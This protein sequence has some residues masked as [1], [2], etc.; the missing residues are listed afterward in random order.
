MKRCA[1]ILRS[2]LPAYPT[3]FLLLFGIVFLFVSAYLRWC[4]LGTN[5]TLIKS[6]VDPLE[7]LALAAYVIEFAACAGFF[8]CFRPGNY[9]VR[10]LL[11]WVCLP[12]LAG[13]L[14][15]IYSCYV[16]HAIGPFSL[17]LLS[18]FG[19]GFHYGLIGLLLVGVFASLAALS[20]ASLPLELPKST[21]STSDDS[22][23]W[24]RMQ[25]F[26]WFFLALLPIIVRIF[27]P[28]IIGHFFYSRVPG[29][30]N[31]A[32]VI[33]QLFVTG[34]VVVL[35]AVWMIGREGWSSLSRALRWPAAQEFALAVAFP[36]GVS[37]LISVGQFLLALFLW[38]VDNSSQS[39]PPHIGGYFSPPSAASLL[40]VFFAF[41]EEIIFR[42]LLQP[43]FIRRYGLLQGIFLVG[44]V[45]AAAHLNRDFSG[46]FTDGSVIVMLCLRLSEALPLSFVAGWLTLRTGSVLPAV[47]THGL[48]NVLGY[49][50]LGPKFW[51]FALVIDFLWVVLAY[52]LFRY[53]PVQMEAAEQRVATIAPPSCQV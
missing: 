8:V 26:I 11:W 29:F 35:I 44:I 16:L 43:R 12:A 48:Q 38:G 22:A 50:P 9:P 34:S 17:T 3:Q 42:G 24:R 27:P 28:N 25:N 45:F 23:S 36:V 18:N 40:L 4:P 7:F 33:A 52:V 53:W 10:R 51:G 47:V 39:S 49:S 46:S 14:V 41:A 1:E 19:P 31:V 30:K 37:A 21:V 13:D 32:A 5:Q 20:S 6:P 15:V 2:I